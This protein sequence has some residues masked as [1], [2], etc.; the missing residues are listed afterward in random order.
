MFHWKTNN[1]IIVNNR[2]GNPYLFRVA[3][4]KKCMKSARIMQSIIT[5]RRYFKH[6]AARNLKYGKLKL[7]LIQLNKPDIGFKLPPVN[8]K[9]GWNRYNTTINKKQKNNCKTESNVKEMSTDSNSGI[10]H[11][12]L[13]LILYTL[14]IPLLLFLKIIVNHLYNTSKIV[15]I[16]LP[17]FKT[18]KESPYNA[19]KQVLIPLPFFKTI[20]ES[21]Y[22]A[23]KQV[24]IPLPFFKII[25]ESPYN[26][27]KQVLIPL[28]FFKTIK[29]SP[30][31][32]LK[33]VLI[34][35]P[36][37]KT[38]N[39]KIYNTPAKVLITVKDN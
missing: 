13:C 8:L 14:F 4:E 31:N 26:A 6:S 17:F 39:C 24:L 32:A 29:E 27:L 34:P 35:L 1:R 10:I 19:L 33:Q 28:P 30:Y 11:Y 37:F 22:N 23:L 16:P 20:K 5:I 7:K 15:L 3:E 12:I 25:K 9:T 38:I 36:F 18:I 21:P 2:T